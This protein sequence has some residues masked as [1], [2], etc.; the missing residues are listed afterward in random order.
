[1]LG[2]NISHHSEI[3]LLMITNSRRLFYVCLTLLMFNALDAFGQCPLSK[4]ETVSVSQWTSCSATLTWS[5]VPGADYYK[6]RYRFKDAVG[7][8]ILPQQITSL[9]YTFTNLVND[10]TYK[11]GVSAFCANGD[12][13]GYKNAQK[14]TLKADIP[15]SLTASNPVGT[16][17]TLSWSSDCPSGA[18]NVRRK[19][20][21]VAGWTTFTNATSGT[22]YE[23]MGLTPNTSYDF[24][25]QSKNGPDVSSWTPSVTMNSGD[26]PVILPAKPNMIVYMLDDGR[27]DNYVPNGGPGWFNSPAI[28][29]IA[30]EGINF[31]YT[32][33]TTSQCAPS[34][35]SIYTG[36]YAH[37]HGAID[38]HSRRFDGLTMV[39]EVLQGAG[40][41]TGFVGKFG[42]F[43]GDPVGF[44][45]WATSDGNNF[46][47]GDYLVNGNDT[48]ITGHISNV[49]Q[50]FALHFLD[51][52]PAGKNFVLFFFTRVPHSPTI[53]RS[54]DT[55]LYV[56]ETMPVPDNFVEYEHNY[57]SYF[58]NGGHRWNYTPQQTDDYKR[59][60]FQC[61]HGSEVNMAAI[62]DW[63]E[64]HGIL[65]ST[66]IMF[67][68]DNGFLQGEHMLEAKQIAQEESIRIPLFVR[69]PAWFPAGTVSTNIQ[70]TNVDIPAT[71][72]DA[73]GI[74]GALETDGTSLYRLYQQSIT[75]KYFFYQ[76]AGEDATPPIRGVRS[77]EY[78]YVKHYCNQLTEEFYD[79]VADPKENTNQIN[80]SDY[81]SLIATY[82]LAMDSIMTE[83]ND[84]E[85][86]IINCFLSSPQ[87]SREVEEDQEA[88]NL[89]N[90]EIYPNPASD[91]FVMNYNDEARE[92][93][94]ISI[95][96]MIDEEVYFK[97]LPNTN[98]FNIMIDATGWSRGIY[99]AT[100]KKG[101]KSFTRKFTIQ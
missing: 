33:P 97:E 98:S 96:N 74:P 94:V 11:F 87:F 78:K 13:G 6:V 54:G 44:D 21:G 55:D 92:D 9:S 12:D 80:N 83:L 25:V 86:S 30:E 1:M 10:T 29:R 75:R 22:V 76:F 18:Y 26:V 65:D 40:Y 50:D 15:R 3:Q 82:R 79:L 70:A 84:P 42:Q 51:N 35:V 93:I 88:F 41:Y 59:T 101:G 67:T 38:N 47:P 77:N 95:Q 62:F 61:L 48:V 34:R 69:Y 19:K 64:V 60:E 2:S 99:L 7:Y 49:Y 4:P 100:V 89:R 58:Y 8:T 23:V 85:P 56:M 20:T 46:N 71:L 14:K 5:A 72:L 31:K 91:Y 28:N 57:P 45:Y 32:F 16:S 36:L 90:V 43:Q 53:P 73:A 39:Q 66:M 27:Y 68:S 63:L 17:V 52:V 24:Q 81:S 37:K